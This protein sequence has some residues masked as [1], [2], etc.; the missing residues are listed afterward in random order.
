VKKWKDRRRRKGKRRSE[1]RHGGIDE[2]EKGRGGVREDM[3]G[4]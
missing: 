4:L 3:E 1:G 2:G